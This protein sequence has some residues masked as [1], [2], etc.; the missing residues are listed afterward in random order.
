M[1]YLVGMAAAVGAAISRASSAA[2][3]VI[4]PTRV[5]PM[6][7]S[8]PADLGVEVEEGAISLV[9]S[10]M[11]PVTSRRTAQRM[12][13]AALGREEE[14]VVVG[15]V[16]GR[17][18]RLGGEDVAPRR[19]DEAEVELATSVSSVIKWGTGRQIA[20]IPEVCCILIIGTWIHRAQTKFQAACMTSIG[21]GGLVPPSSPTDR[22]RPR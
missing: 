11:S 9:T 17:E 19:L 3:P 13:A 12:V 14:A 6:L 20:R 21:H 22:G 1:A 15:P 10:V 4:C 8:A 16:E 18:E 2:L 7:V 5:R